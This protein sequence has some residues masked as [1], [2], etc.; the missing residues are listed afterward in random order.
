MSRGSP[1][2][3]VLGGLPGWVF[4]IA[5]MSYKLLSDF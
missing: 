1:L 4:R 5:P 3:R 2:R